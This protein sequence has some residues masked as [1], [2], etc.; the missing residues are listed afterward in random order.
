MNTSARPLKKD[1]AEPAWRR[2]GLARMLM[3]E[4]MAF[5]SESRAGSLVQCASTDPRPLCEH[6]G[7]RATN[8]MRLVQS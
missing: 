3:R 8:E 1:V 7:F 5:A 4:A 2:E 6:P